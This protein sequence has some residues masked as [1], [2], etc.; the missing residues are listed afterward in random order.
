[1]MKCVGFYQ[2]MRVETQKFLFGSKENKNTEHDM[3]AK[4]KV[5]ESNLN[6]T[7]KG[8]KEATR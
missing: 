2:V 8:P 1:M 5:E 3:L 7:K 4:I 6:Q